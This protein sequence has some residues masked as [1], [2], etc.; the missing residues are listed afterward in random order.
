PGT[1]SAM[2]VKAGPATI[3]PRPEKAVGDASSR[4]AGLGPGLRL[5]GA[6]FLRQ[7]GHDHS[8][9]LLD[10]VEHLV[11]GD[12]AAETQAVPPGSSDVGHDGGVVRVELEPLVGRVAG[13]GALDADAPA[14]RGGVARTEK[15]E[16]LRGTLHPPVAFPVVLCTSA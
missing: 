12:R 14:R 8:V 6:V 16:D 11:V 5:C 13:G 7:L 9:G 2:V 3:P 1:W 10:R 15:G 4:R